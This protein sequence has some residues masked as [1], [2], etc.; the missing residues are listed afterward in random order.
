VVGVTSFGFIPPPDFKLSGSSTLDDE[1][2]ALLDAA[3]GRR[4]DNC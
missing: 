4:A 2:L 1:F 3:C